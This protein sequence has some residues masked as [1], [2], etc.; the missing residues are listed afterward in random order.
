MTAPNSLLHALVASLVER[1]Q[2]NVE[3]LECRPEWADTAEFCANYGIP[4]EDTC[5]TILVVLKTNP[6]SYVACLVRSDTKLDVNHKLAAVTGTKRMSFASGDETVT[7]TGMMIGGVTVL[8]LPEGMRLLIDDQVMQR[9]RIVVG[10]GNRSSK[11]LLAP[12]ELLK[13]PLAETADLCV[14]RQAPS[15]EAENNQ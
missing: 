3:V 5:N 9:E 14:P 1:L 11:V 2:L 6:R 4:A 15:P 13:V 10:G 8:G 7:L 12:S